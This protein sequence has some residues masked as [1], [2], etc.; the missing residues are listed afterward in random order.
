[1]R[2]RCTDL[3]LYLLFIGA[4]N[5]PRGPRQV[6]GLGVGAGGSRGVLGE[7]GIGVRRGWGVWGGGERLRLYFVKP[8][9]R[10]RGGLPHAHTRAHPRMRIPQGPQPA[11][12]PRERAPA[13]RCARCVAP[14]EEGHPRYRVEIQIK[15]DHCLYKLSTAVPS[16]SKLAQARKA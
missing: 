6:G 1:M 9:V 3:R 8:P 15:M 5:K 16:D 2:R 13:A 7:T 11:T 14:G 12:G 10:V 4:T